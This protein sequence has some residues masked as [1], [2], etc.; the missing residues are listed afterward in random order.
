[1]S[2]N[3]VIELDALFP[4]P[5]TIK[6]NDVTLNLLPITAGQLPAVLRAVEP[7]LGGITYIYGDQAAKGKEMQLVMSLIAQS[8][9]AINEAIAVMIKQP[10]EWVKDLPVS[11]L[12]QLLSLVVEVNRDFF[13]QR[14]EQVVNSL[15]A[16]KATTATRGAI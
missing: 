4:T 2:N 12:V 14:A 10:V 7:V 8:G 6:I 5:K 3:Q 1:M 13:I 11:T 15:A 9:D 16:M